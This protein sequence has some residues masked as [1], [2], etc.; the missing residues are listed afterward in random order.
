MRRVRFLESRLGRYE[1][2]I[3]FDPSSKTADAEE[4]FDYEATNDEFN[5]MS[6]EK[7]NIFIDDEDE[8]QQRVVCQIGEGA[9][10]I[11]CK[12]VDERTDGEMCKK[13][14][15]AEEGK[16]TF[17]NVQNIYKEFE[18]LQRMSHP[19]ICKCIGMNTQEKINK[20]HS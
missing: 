18:V 3:P 11:T 4:G 8:S 20:Q 13:V 6:I 9:A 19:S 15:K 5:E 1:D 12:V 2:V 14:L 7:K 10:S 17:K 16:T